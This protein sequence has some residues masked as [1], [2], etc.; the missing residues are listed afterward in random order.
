LVAVF[1]GQAHYVFDRSLRLL[2]LDAVERVEVSL[3]TNFA[4]YLSSQHGAFAHD[5]QLAIRDQ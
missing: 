2:L 1:R 4:Q 3:R 5:E